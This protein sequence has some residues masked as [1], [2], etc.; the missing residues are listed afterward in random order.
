MAP[1]T[2]NPGSGI[3]GKQIAGPPI[4]SEAD[5]F[6][7]CPDCGQAFDKRDLGELMHHISPVTSR[8]RTTED[9]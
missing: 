9:A 7:L 5:H 2:D 4:G 3:K 8:C 6:Q 1:K